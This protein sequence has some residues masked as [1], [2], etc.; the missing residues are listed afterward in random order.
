MPLIGKEKTF[1]FFHFTLPHPPFVFNKDGFVH[2][3]RPFEQNKE[4]YDNQ[5]DFIELKL[6]EIIQRLKDLNQFDNTYILIMADHGYRK[7]TPIDQHEHIS[8]LR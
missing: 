5:L 1:S 7:L 3:R 4:N 2:L 8:T 6:G